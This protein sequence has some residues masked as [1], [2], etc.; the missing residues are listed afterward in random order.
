MDHKERDVCYNKNEFTVCRQKNLHQSIQ[1][2]SLGFWLVDN[3][4][5]VKCNDFG[6]FESTKCIH[7]FDQLQDILS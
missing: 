5:F 6:V 2:R 3:R 7:F 4:V 1:Q